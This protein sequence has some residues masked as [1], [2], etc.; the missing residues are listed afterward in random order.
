MPGLRR[1]PSLPSKAT[2]Q[3]LVSVLPAHSQPGT[4]AKLLPSVQYCI[5]M[6]EIMLL[7]GVSVY[8]TSAVV[9]VTLET[10]ALFHVMAP[11]LSAALPAE[12]SS[13]A[14]S[15]CLTV[16]A[17]RMGSLTNSPPEEVSNFTHFEE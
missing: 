7:L 15:I 2:L 9:D 1:G 8:F 3:K 4:L 10:E 6:R 16:S 12:R 5:P 11:E 14:A 13:P 17:S